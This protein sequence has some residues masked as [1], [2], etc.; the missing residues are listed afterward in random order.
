MG[1]L[2]HIEGELLIC[3]HDFKENIS[4]AQERSRVSR[5]NCPQENYILWSA[6]VSEGW[7]RED[8]VGEEVD[9]VQSTAAVVRLAGLDTT[10]TD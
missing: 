9:G 2:H 8:G 7:Q 6:E 5:H 1:A 4:C 10:Y 3:G